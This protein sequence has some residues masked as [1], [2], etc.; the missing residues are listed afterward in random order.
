VIAVANA[1][2]V[3]WTKRDREAGRRAVG[4]L[5]AKDVF[6]VFRMV[7]R[8]EL[9]TDK[10]YQRPTSLKRSRAIAYDFQPKLFGSLWVADRGG[11]GD[12]YVV[13]GAHRLMASDIIGV[14]Y[15]PKLPCQI[16]RTSSAKE[17]MSIYLQLTEKRKQ[18][19]AYQRF[20]IKLQL[21]DPA[22]LAIL[23]LMTK[24]GYELA[25]AEN[26]FGHVFKDN[27]IYA[28][29]TLE[30]IYDLCGE[31]ALDDVLFV[32]RKAYSGTASSLSGLIISGLSRF[33]ES[34]TTPKTRIVQNLLTAVDRGRDHM[35]IVAEA[36]RK[37]GNDGI[38]QVEAI[39]DV[40]RKYA[41]TE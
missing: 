29:S 10:T 16:Y 34:E 24:H 41:T 40:F 25:A 39:S 13:D 22:A 6:G 23:A 18:H 26:T 27:T 4:L 5:E 30:R 33:M 3:D 9:K 11:R 15:L 21:K 7:A 37:A 31:K 1:E 17:E 12:L 14:E 36:V 20:L 28:I 38:P 19:N 8:G 32:L 35:T 2:R